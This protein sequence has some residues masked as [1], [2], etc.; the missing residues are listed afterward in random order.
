MHVDTSP[1]GSLQDGLFGALTRAKYN[2]GVFGK[3]TNDQSN[4]LNIA[5][6]Q[7]SM[8]YI[9]SPLDYN[10]YNGLTYVSLT[11]LTLPKGQGT[12]H[13]SHQ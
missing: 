8:G 9:D 7:K 1:A 3:V 2:V 11:S 5:V 13:Y 12:S 6:E 4:I 10:N